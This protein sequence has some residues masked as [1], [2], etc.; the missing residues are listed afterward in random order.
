MD[1]AAFEKAGETFVL[2]KRFSGQNAPAP[3]RSVRSVRIGTERRAAANR[4]VRSLTRVNGF[5]KSRISAILFTGRSA[6]VMG[7]RQH[8]YY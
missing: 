8:E 6:A 3:E 4:P 7:K 2:A 1:P 5:T